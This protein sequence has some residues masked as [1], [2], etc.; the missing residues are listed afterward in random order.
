MNT[1]LGFREFMHDEDLVLPELCFEPVDMKPQRT[2]QLG[3][4]LADRHS[5][6]KTSAGECRQQYEN[7]DYLHVLIPQ[8]RMRSADA[9]PVEGRTQHPKTK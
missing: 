4:H 5:A 2:T 9:R 8:H 7:I 3:F 6:A 1:V